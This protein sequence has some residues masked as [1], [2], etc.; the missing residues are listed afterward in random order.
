MLNKTK[1]II[2]ALAILLA[3]SASINIWQGASLSLTSSVKQHQPSTV[4]LMT[5]ADH[6]PEFKSLL[7]KSIAI[8]R[9]EN[10]DRRT[11]PAQTL[12][13]F[14]SF[15]DW[16]ALAMPWNILKDQTYPLLYEQIDQSLDYFY[17][18][19]DRPLPELEGKGLYRNSLQYYEP[20]RSWM[21]IFTKSW[22]AYLDTTDSWNNNYY[23]KAYADRRFGLDRGWYEDP[24]KWTTFNQFFARYLKSPGQRPIAQS[25]EQSIVISPAD[26]TPQG[27]WKID[28]NSNLVNKDGVGVKSSTIYSI[29][30]LLGKDSAYR[31]AFADGVLTHTFLDVI[32]Y[33]RYHFPV[34]GTV[35]E[36]NIIPQDDAVG[37]T[38]T[39]SPEKKKYLLDSAIPGWQFIET[40]GYVVIQ[41][42][43]YGLVAVIPVGMSQ[44]SSVNFEPNVKVGA[45]FNKGDMLGYFL[46]GG[47]DCVMLF[48]KGAGFKLTVP[49]NDKDG[50]QHLLMGET[51]GVLNGTN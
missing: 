46:F 5:L 14:Y 34:G 30:D 31:D 41:T 9:A 8:A 37:G 13:E 39:W 1:L 18:I 48:Q 16:A 28:A 3:V 51:F 6:N 22:G 24:S 40:R 19:V 42:M 49:G 38:I 45:S 32:D 21:I 25:A 50:Y 29:K 4:E 36:I 43:K 33:H 47:S 15:I 11:N 10:P 44:V 20:F 7:I 12:E 27:V 35:K 23:M 17:F 2:V 26:S